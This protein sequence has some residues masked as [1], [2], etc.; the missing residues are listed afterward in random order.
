MEVAAQVE[1]I[2]GALGPSGL[3]LGPDQD[4]IGE[5]PIEN[6]DAMYGK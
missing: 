3:V 6:I 4:M 2:V 1:Q 5:I